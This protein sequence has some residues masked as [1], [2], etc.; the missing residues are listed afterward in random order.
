MDLLVA[1][2]N[3]FEPGREDVDGMCTHKGRSPAAPLLPTT[4]CCTLQ[5]PCLDRDIRK[6]GGKTSPS[7]PLP[8]YR[9]KSAERIDHIRAELQGLP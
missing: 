4:R 5:A 6:R 2:G 8:D 9:K 1:K 7:T 3:C